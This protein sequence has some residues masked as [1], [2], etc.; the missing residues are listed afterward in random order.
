VLEIEHLDVYYGAVQILKG[1]SLDVKEGELVTVIGANGAGKTTL[2]MSI[3]GI[4]RPTSGTIKFFEKRI[5]K[6]PTHTI[7]GLGIV[8]VPQGRLLFPEMTTLDNLVLGAY[9]ATDGKTRNIKQRLEDVYAHFEILREREKQIAG[10]LSGGQQQMLAIGRALMANP[11]LL[12]LDEPSSGLAPIVVE[13]IANILGKLKNK[14]LTI[15][16]VEQNASLALNLAD[17]AYI[18]ENGSIVAC[19]KASELAKSELVKM[20]YIGI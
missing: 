2:M 20:A 1:I 8:Q 4:A 3:S 5:D 18:L 7:V 11:K 14:G 16:L 19:G 15:M 17:R 9:R 6:S 10:T 12:L 13:E